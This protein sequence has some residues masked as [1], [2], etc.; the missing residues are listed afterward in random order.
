MEGSEGLAYDDPWSDS[1]TTVMGADCPWGL[2]LS[3]HT[4]MHVTLHMPRSP[5][6]HLPPL[7]VAV[8]GIDAMVVHMEESELDNL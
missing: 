5:M 6:D 7:E 4:P 2:A 3:P 1:N 8:I